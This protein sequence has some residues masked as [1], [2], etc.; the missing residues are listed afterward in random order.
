MA[1]GTKGRGGG[2]GRCIFHPLSD[3]YLE[4]NE[5]LHPCSSHIPTSAAHVYPLFLHVIPSLAS[6][7][8]PILFYY[9]GKYY[10]G[11]FEWP[12]WQP[13]SWCC[14]LLGNSISVHRG[15]AMTLSD[16]DEIQFVGSP[17]GHM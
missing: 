13:Y 7:L 15:F 4:T 8:R 17:G 5:I 9:L 16:L 2:I 12:K 1:V 6:F 10:D 14:K 11:H 3:S